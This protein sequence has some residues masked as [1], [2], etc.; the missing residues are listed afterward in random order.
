MNKTLF[1]WWL[2]LVKHSYCADSLGGLGSAGVRSPDRQNSFDLGLPASTNQESTSTSTPFHLSSAQN[3]DSESVE[4]SHRSFSQS[5]IP[6]GVPSPK[7]SGRSQS[8]QRRLDLD[9]SETSKRKIIGESLNADS[10]RAESWPRASSQSASVHAESSIVDLAAEIT[11][12]TSLAEATDQP[13]DETIVV[14]GGRVY[15]N[16]TRGGIQR[17]SYLLARPFHICFIVASHLT[18]IFW[19]Q[20]KPSMVTTNQSNQ[21]Y[22]NIAM[23]LWRHSV[24]IWKNCDESCFQ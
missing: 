13:V 10:S 5:S 4:P 6:R 3:T 17:S 12:R 16:L 24:Q 22:A 20:P 18:V 2:L 9:G 1:C 15:H 14:G 23:Q 19:G 7:N 8:M 11:A 21:I